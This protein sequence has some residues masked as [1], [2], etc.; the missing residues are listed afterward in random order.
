MKLRVGNT[1]K[2]PLLTMVKFI[3]KMFLVVSVLLLIIFT[4]STCL[5][6]LLGKRLAWK[7]L[8]TERIQGIYCYCPAQS[9]VS[10]RGQTLCINKISTQSTL[11]YF[12]KWLPATKLSI[13][14]S[15]QQYIRLK[16]LS[17]SRK[18]CVA[19]KTRH[20]YIYSTYISRLPRWRRRLR[21]TNSVF[22]IYEFLAIFCYFS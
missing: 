19:E 13:Y 3:S 1:V 7:T 11:P 12:P 4:S 2:F 9:G 10:D 5:W 22:A 17:W 16:L 18:F 20:K 21:S 8:M 15:Y 14:N 6:L